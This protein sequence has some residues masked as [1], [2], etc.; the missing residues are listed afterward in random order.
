MN[1]LQ[2]FQQWIAN[3]PPLFKLKSPFVTVK[4]IQT[5]ALP[6]NEEYDGNPRL[7]FLYQYLCTKLLTCSPRYELVA[8]EVQLN[9]ATGRTIGAVDLILKDVESNQH[10]HW[11]VAIKFYLLHQGVWYGPNAHDQL[12][13]KLERMLNHQLKMSQREE[14]RQQLPLN[15]GPSEHLLM[16]GRLYVNP[17]SKEPIPTTCL[18]YELD[19]TQISGFWCYQSQWEQIKQPL[20]ALPKPL[21]ATGNEEFLDPIDKPSDRF[22][23]AQTKDGQF[24]FVVP[25]TWP[26]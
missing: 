3:T 19:P 10:E 8:E 17:F 23:H 13:K 5:Q 15:S 22:V 4:D 20:Y 6:D 14:F 18:G 25:D 11:E 1:S 16:Q 24:W 12:H 9:D 26:N 21:W 2:R 7:G